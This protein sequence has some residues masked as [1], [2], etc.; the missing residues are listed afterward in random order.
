MQSENAAACRTVPERVC[1]G[2]TGFPPGCSIPGAPGESVNPSDLLV[3]LN[4]A[5]FSLSLFRDSSRLS[6]LRYGK[7]QSFFADAI[8]PNTFLRKLPLT[9]IAS[10]SAR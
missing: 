10:S 2:G 8:A 5:F 3:A 1:Q 7:L 4:P 9:L 6:S